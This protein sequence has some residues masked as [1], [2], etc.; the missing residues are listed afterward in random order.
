M[1]LMQQFVNMSTIM[2]SLFFFSLWLHCGHLRNPVR[3]ATQLM[4]HTVNLDID[5]QYSE[6]S[7]H[8]SRKHMRL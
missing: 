3:V 4:Q 7:D 6:L 2:L 1:I 5:H 8:T